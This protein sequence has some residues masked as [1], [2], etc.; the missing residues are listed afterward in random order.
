MK[1]LTLKA[2]SGRVLDQF[3]FNVILLSL[4]NNSTETLLNKLSTKDY[5]L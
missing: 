5:I 1:M 3:F 4:L 2:E